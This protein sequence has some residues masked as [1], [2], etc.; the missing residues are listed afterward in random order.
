MQKNIFFLFNLLQDVAVLRPLVRLSAEVTRSRKLLM[1]SSAFLKRDKT[2]AWL[3]E[4]D[5]LAESV[6]GA[7]REFD[8]PFEIAAR[9][10]E[11][12]GIV[13]AGSESAL[14][15][16]R[17]T[18][19]AF[20][21]APGR[22]LK[23]TVQ[24]GFECIGF[25]HNARHDTAFGRTVA[26]AADVL[27]GWFPA[28]RC[29]SLAS[30][31]AGKVICTGPTSLLPQ[32]AEAWKVDY[33]VEGL[34]CENLHSVR[35]G[36]GE[37]SRDAFMVAF[38]GFASALDTQGLKVGLRPHPASKRVFDMAAAP[39]A[40]KI[41]DPIYRL[42]LARFAY[43]FSPPSSVVIDLI[44][45]GVPTA[46]WR[47]PH[48][49]MD[50]G[51]Y[52]GL[53]LVSL[54]GDMLA[55]RERALEQRAELLAAQDAFLRR[56][57]IL[58]DPAEIRR[59]FVSLIRRGLKE[60]AREEVAV[61]ARS[62]LVV[63]DNITATQTISFSA[64]FAH[65]GALDGWSLHLRRHHVADDA[66]RIDRTL[67]AAAPDVVI[68]SRLTASTAPQWI[69]Q[70]RARG[71]AVIVHLDDDLLSVPPEIAKTRVVDYCDP[72]RLA[73]LRDGLDRADL[74][75]ASTPALAE[76][77]REYGGGAKVV[78]GTVYRA[79]DGALTGPKRTATP[80]FGYMGTGSHAAD[81][82]MIAPAIA[83]VL[84]R[85]PEWRFEIMGSLA[86]PA[87]LDR[88]GDRVRSH[89]PTADYDA[90]LARL[91]GLGW[92]AGLAPVRDTPFNTCKADTKWVEYT[93]SGIPTVASRSKVYADACADGAGLL[94][95]DT[96]E[97]S[98]AVEHLL[99]DAA[100]GEALITRARAKLADIYSMDRL[101]GQVADILHQAID[102]A[103]TRA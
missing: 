88:F 79:H 50:V 61:R 40:V 58:T 37:A 15:A 96:A 19:A 69:D 17:E 100:E 81:L 93:V 66:A 102:E 6:R 26:S 22:Y 54:P 5:D 53:P 7:V 98:Q 78:A 67:D 83:A 65:G 74:V 76:R 59:R 75:Y 27:A 23:V 12:D 51:H 21:A 24:H 43:A 20:R 64:P 45:A 84:D 92:W 77:L 73:A 36:T 35:F 2:G 28:E 39:N 8:T 91:S 56:T 33:D 57:G 46:V 89:P 85:H 80:T 31:E 62:A 95:G 60:E 32:A 71:A 90:F 49:D 99:S 87:A 70:A 63:A 41:A 13:F 14:N 25:L 11:G 101:A 38:N 44:A 55:F 52:A 3:R 10:A 48:G 16:H 103:K 82:D 29:T 42:P 72:K 34:I 30:G 94:A 9:M 18:H 97:W 4:I 86:P 1:V 68:L 47:D